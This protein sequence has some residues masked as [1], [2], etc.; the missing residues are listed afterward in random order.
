M[1]AASRAPYEWDVVRDEKLHARNP[2]ARLAGKPADPQEPDIDLLQATI[3]FAAT[4]TGML[5]LEGGPPPWAGGHPC[6]FANRAGRPRGVL[7]SLKG[8]PLPGG[9]RGKQ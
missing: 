3:D 2:M 4:P 6:C 7:L 9:D 1:T 5:L 8:K